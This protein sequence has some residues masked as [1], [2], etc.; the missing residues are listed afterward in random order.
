M[1]QR[2]F[3]FKPFIS[4]FRLLYTSLVSRLAN[5][6]IFL[7]VFPLLMFTPLYKNKWRRGSGAPLG[8]Y[9][10]GIWPLITLNQ[11]GWLLLVPV[12]RWLL[13]LPRP[14]RRSRGGIPIYLERR[15]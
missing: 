14:R 5:F 12:A 4:D 13:L 2:L 3:R 10:L 1:R 9:T 11:T 15:R 8:R 6:R 7:L